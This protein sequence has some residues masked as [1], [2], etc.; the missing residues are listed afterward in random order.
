MEQKKI[1]MVDL[2]NLVEQEMIDFGFCK[3]TFYGYRSVWKKLQIFAG[4]AYYSPKLCADFLAE[5]YQIDSIEECRGFTKTQMYYLRTV[6][7]LADYFNFGT[8][9][10]R[11]NIR[12]DI[13]WNTLTRFIYFVH[14]CC[15]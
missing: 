3:T 1:K 12:R 8:F 14:K 2:C 11:R 4:D 5:E 6:R 7:L 13:K 10:R 15:Y 9:F